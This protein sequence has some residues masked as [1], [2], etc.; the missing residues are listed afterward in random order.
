MWYLL[1]GWLALHGEIVTLPEGLK[2]TVLFVSQECAVN[3]VG[4]GV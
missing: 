3:N 2:N 1:Q 4:F